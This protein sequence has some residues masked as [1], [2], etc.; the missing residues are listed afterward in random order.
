MRNL[1]TLMF[2]GAGAAALALGAAAQAQSA[3][4]WTTD[5]RPPAGA[6][7]ADRRKD[8]KPTAAATRRGLPE[9]LYGLS[10]DPLWEHRSIL[11]DFERIS[12]ELDRQ[13]ADMR[14]RM[15]ELQR[16]AESPDGEVSS[17]RDGVFGGMSTPGD[18]GVYA[19]S[20]EITQTGDGPAKIV[21]RSFGSCAGPP[22]DADK[23]LMGAPD[24]ASDGAIRI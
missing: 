18:G 17:V 9:A 8:G 1:R 21:R 12:A 16:W 19:Q 15:E 14:R 3:P 13:M 10:H 5:K 2:A 11:A 22:A 6:A 4:I 7:E 23:A 20:V 24:R